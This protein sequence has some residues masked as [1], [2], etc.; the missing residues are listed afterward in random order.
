VS[1]NN[2]LVV[3]KGMLTPSV[4]MVLKDMD[5]RQTRY[6]R[7]LAVPEQHAYVLARTCSAEGV[8]SQAKPTTRISRDR[9]RAVSGGYML[10]GQVHVDEDGTEKF[11]HVLEAKKVTE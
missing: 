2:Q 7:I 11:Q 3:S 9:L 8:P 4:G 6:V 10:V 1:D 5:N